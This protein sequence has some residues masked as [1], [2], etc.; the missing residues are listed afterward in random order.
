MKPI[1]VID[2]DF[3]LLGEIDTYSSLQWIRRWHKPG[4]FELHIDRSMHNA[5][6][7]QEDR[8]IFLPDH[9]REA[10]IIKHREI[11]FDDDGKETLVV[12]G[13]MLSGLLGR[14]IT[15]PPAEKAYDYVNGT[16]ETIMKHY[17]HANCIQPED[18]GRIIPHMVC[19]TDLQ[20]GQQIQFQTR[21]KPLDEE[22]EK[23]SIS[24]GLGWAVQLDLEN[25]H[26][27]FEVLEGRDLTSDQDRLP[28]AIFSIEYDNV[29]SQSY[30][31]SS[32]GHKNVALVGGQGEGAERKIISI[33]D[34]AGLD[35][36]EMFVDARDIGTNDQ[37]EQPLTEQDI[38]RMLMDRGNEKLAETARVENFESKLL[39]YSNL[40][41][42]RDYDLGDVVTIQNRNWGVRIHVR[43]VEVKETYESIGV[44]LEATFGKAAPTLIEKIKQVTEQPVA[45]ISSSGEPGPQGPA[46]VGLQYQWQG[47]SLGIKRDTDASYSYADLKGPKGDKGDKGDIGPQG[48][49]GIQGIQGIKGDKGDP[50]P[51]GPQGVQGPKGDKGDIGPQGPQGPQGVQGVKG[52]VGAQ[53]PSGP[54]GDVGPQGPP[55]P[56]G[57]YVGSSPPADPSLLWID[58]TN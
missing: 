43:I 14:R 35:R 58:T 50:G 27:V 30:V 24:S 45:E 38:R 8:I 33:G 39:P 2:T 22:Q 52:D 48:A 25:Q 29:E 31:S 32:I 12:R 55:G 6:I 11:G 10:A 36:Y 57:Y 13:P 3:S 7:L 41:Y 9:P 5:N 34:A 53:G 17:V 44:K 28:P 49:Q 40:T 1:R 51:S 21:Y 56:G 4:E 16:V 54:K 46:G 47:T 19:A 42:R 26:F 18:E 15:Y 20:R 23:L 37:S